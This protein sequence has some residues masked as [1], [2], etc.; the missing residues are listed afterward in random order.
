MK[1]NK[2]QYRETGNIGTQDEDKQNTT[3][4]NWQ[5][6]LHKMKINK[7]QHRETGN[8]VYTR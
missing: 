6:R 4:R 5:Y 8:I 7:T 2:T 3:Q 1:I